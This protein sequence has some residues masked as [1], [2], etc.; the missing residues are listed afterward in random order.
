MAQN[1]GERGRDIGTERRAAY[2]KE[3][4]R[5]V[6]RVMNDLPHGV[7]VF[8]G[9]AVDP[10]KRHGDLDIGILGDEPL[11]SGVKMVLR[12]ALEE[13]IVPWEIDIIDFACVDPS[14]KAEAM[15]KIIVWKEK[16]AT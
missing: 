3:A 13:S 14:F 2:F 4:K 11:D 9:R 15:A 7:F 12:E 5:L 10:T 8:G 16:N 1:V 6:L